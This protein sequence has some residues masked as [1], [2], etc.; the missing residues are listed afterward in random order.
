MLVFDIQI[1]Q[2]DHASLTVSVKDNFDPSKHLKLID[3][4]GPDIW[5]LLMKVDFHKNLDQP[6]SRTLTQ[7][8]SLCMD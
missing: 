5:E 7:E 3:V 8:K 1:L 4:T 2:Y 6:Q